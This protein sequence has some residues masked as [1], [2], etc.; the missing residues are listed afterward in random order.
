[1]HFCIL[2]F[3]NLSDPQYLNKGVN[4]NNLRAKMW[5]AIFFGIYWKNYLL[6]NNIYMSI[7]DKI[8]N[9]YKLEKY[10]AGNKSTSL[11]HYT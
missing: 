10:S 1:M 6:N 11:D 4:Q 3:A 7:T 5:W 9:G 2:I 8:L